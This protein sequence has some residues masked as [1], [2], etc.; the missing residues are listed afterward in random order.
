MKKL[1][2]FL[3]VIMTISVTAQSIS[4]NWV[5]PTTLNPP[6]G[7]CHIQATGG[8]NWFTYFVQIG[9]VIYWEQS[10]NFY[11]LAPGVYNWGF[12]DLMTNQLH[13]YPSVIL[14]CSP[15]MQLLNTPIINGIKQTGSD[16]FGVDP[17]RKIF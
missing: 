10:G 5:Q 1:L 13:Y 16:L 9:S 12:C 3:F 4:G 11:G 6:N 14:D 17:N 2:L 8:N 7:E 15:Y